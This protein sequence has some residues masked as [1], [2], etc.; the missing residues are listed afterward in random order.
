MSGTTFTSNNRDHSNEQGFQWE[1]FCDKCGNGWRSQFKTN[2][3]GVAASF[4]RAAGSFFGGTAARASWAG[5]HLK[6]A[7]RGGAW[8][9]A[10]AEAIAEGKAKFKQCTRCG[11]WVCPEVCWN[12][13]RGLCEECAPDEGEQAAAIQA[14]VA[15]EQ[16]WDKARKSDQ[17]D[18]RDMKKKQVAGGCPSCG[19]AGGGGKFCAEC[20]APLKPQKLVCACGTELQPKAKFCPECGKP[21]GK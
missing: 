7:L 3:L 4:L 6:D 13:E 21:A 1:F 19:A 14:Q 16:M 11:K 17:T 9:E 5:E 15:V 8:D 2:K 10:F 12:A 18:G 20:G